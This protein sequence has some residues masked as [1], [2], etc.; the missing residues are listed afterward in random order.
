VLE[1]SKDN[2]V[3]YVQYAH[4]RVQSVLRRAR[5]AGLAVDDATLGAADLGRLGHEAELKLARAIAEWPRLIEIAARGHE[6][7]R[8]A[9][10]L[11]DLA[12]DFHSLWNRGTE[13][14]ALRMLQEGDPATSQARIALARACAV[15]ISTGLAILGVTP[16]DEMR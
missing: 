5:E 16:V 6:P 7:H 3:F 12:S 8:I 10:Y 13:E 14:P 9:F 11:Y 2:P 4:A 15:V 1:Q